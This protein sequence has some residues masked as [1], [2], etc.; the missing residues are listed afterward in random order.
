MLRCGAGKCKQ[1]G[2][3]C[4][5]VLLIVGGFHARLLALSSDPDAFASH[6]NAVRVHEVLHA[7]LVR[8][9]V[10]LELETVGLRYL[11]HESLYLGEL[12]L[13]EV[14]H[15]DTLQ[16]TSRAGRRRTHRSE[17]I[18]VSYYMYSV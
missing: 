9:G 14:H 4:L 6:L 15:P 12:F 8:H 17:F 18:F 1:R 2:S 13:L 16:K 11:V 10:S 5:P 3:P 7:V